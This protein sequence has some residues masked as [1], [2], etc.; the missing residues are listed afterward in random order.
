MARLIRRHRRLFTAAGIIAVVAL[1]A[2]VAAMQYKRSIPEAKLVAAEG[3]NLPLPVSTEIGWPS[4]GQAG[5]AVAGVGLIG[6]SPNQKPQPIASLVKVMTAYVI[7]KNHPLNN[8]EPGPDVE[9]QAADV[10][11]YV[12]R[13][14]NA[15][16]VVPVKAGDKMTERELLRGLLLASGNNLADVLAEWHSGS[17]EAFVGAMNAEAQ[18]LGMTNTTYADAA[19]LLPASASTAH[20]QIMLA[21]A[22]MA[23]PAFAS[24]VRETQASL[25]GAGIVFNTNSELARGNVVGIKTGWT[26]EAGACFLFASEKHIGDRTV[27]VIGATL[28]QDTLADAF[29]RSRELMAAGSDSVSLVTVAK[30]GQRMGVIDTPWGATSDAVLAGDANLLLIPGMEVST[31]LAL[32]TTAGITEGAEV[33]TVKF[34]A[35]DQVIELPLK[36]SATVPNPSL[37]WR[38]TRIR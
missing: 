30:D 6:E 34:T 21:H 13:G 7:L 10:Q 8:G 12:S 14:A 11:D 20:D 33:G 17:V 35:G 28:G 22:A 24:I 5:V 31:D 15:E 4:Q 26:E 27:T 36:A 2:A 37:G 29:A 1:V 16:S 32:G 19:G 3:Q 18:A 25:P 38:M 9:F 23:L